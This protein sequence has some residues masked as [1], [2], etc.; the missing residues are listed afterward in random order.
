MYL[1][2]VT[3]KPFKIYACVHK[4]IL[5]KCHKQLHKKHMIILCITAFLSLLL[6]LIHKEE[7]LLF[8]VWIAVYEA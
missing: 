5:L 6:E 8:V 2:K 1:T 4:D 7:S 3:T